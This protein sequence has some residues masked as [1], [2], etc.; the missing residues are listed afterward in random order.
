MR[1][2]ET[3]STQDVALELA[4]VG[5]VSGTIVVA[6][7]QRSGRGRHGRRWDDAPD[8]G[9]LA[10]TLLLDTPPHVLGIV[11]HA[12]GLAVAE[13]AARM[14]GADVRLKWPNDVVVRDDG[15]GRPGCLRKLAGVLVQ[16][17]DVVGRDVLLIG[18]GLNVDLHGM[19][20][21]DDR[22]CLAGLLEPGRDGIASDRRPVDRHQV[23]VDMLAALDARLGHLLHAPSEVLDDY[24]ERSDTLGRAVDVD[25]PDGRRF[26]GTAEAVDVEGR[27][28]VDAGGHREQVVTGTV[29]DRVVSTGCLAEEGLR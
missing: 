18:V 16:R 13:A 17:E 3:D 8:G 23:L 10:M 27:L 11:P 12:V 14:T 28:V 26:S 29:R 15:P 5:A 20:P 7:S 9:T 22:V 4:R 1:S 2:S 24:R 19:P 6:D 21:H 25:L